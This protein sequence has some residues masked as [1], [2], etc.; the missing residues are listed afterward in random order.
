MKG[1]IRNKDKI[2]ARARGGPFPKEVT[3]VRKYRSSAEGV[4]DVYQ[5]CVRRWLE[6]KKMYSK[7]FEI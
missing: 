1:N 3:K 4:A 5:K 7:V 2:I 6:S